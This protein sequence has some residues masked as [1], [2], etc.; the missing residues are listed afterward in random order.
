MTHLRQHQRSQQTGTSMTKAVQQIG[1]AQQC[2]CASKWQKPTTGK[3][4]LS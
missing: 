1:R 3:G 4:C 2:Q